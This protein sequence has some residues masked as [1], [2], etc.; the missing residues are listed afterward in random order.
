MKRSQFLFSFLLSSLL[1]CGCTHTL[2]THQQVL[3]K[4]RTKDDVLKEF[5]QPDEINKGTGIEQWTYNMDK[6]SEKRVQKKSMP[7]TLPDT[8]VRDSV[9]HIKQEK[10]TKYVKFMFDGDGKVIGYKAEGVDLTENKKDSFGKSLVTITG[11]ILLIS[12]LVALELYN[13]G[14]FDQ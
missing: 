13:N 3:Q 4:T 14:A 2:Y 9:Q 7:N 12:G 10:F 1:F 6:A 11:G 8:L 5:G